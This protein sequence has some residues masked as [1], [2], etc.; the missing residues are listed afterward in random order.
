MVLAVIL[1]IVVVVIG[2][3]VELYLF[4]HGLLWHRE[5]KRDPRNFGPPR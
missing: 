1:F 3:L 2:L 5:E 4:D